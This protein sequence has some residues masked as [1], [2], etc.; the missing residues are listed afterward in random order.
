[1]RFIDSLEKWLSDINKIFLFFLHPAIK[2]VF[3]FLVGF[4]GAHVILQHL[5]DQLSLRIDPYFYGF[6]SGTKNLIDVLTEAQL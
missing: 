4:W 2:L 1:M 6:F 5:V 3:L